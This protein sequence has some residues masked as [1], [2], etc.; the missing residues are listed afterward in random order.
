MVTFLLAASR[1]RSQNFQRK[2]STPN[3]NFLIVIIAFCFRY[4]YLLTLG[5]L[6]FLG[7]SKVTLMNLVYIILFL[8]F[9]SSG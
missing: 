7:F 6:F 5:A 2:S 1:D 9:F 3:P 4:S 8:V